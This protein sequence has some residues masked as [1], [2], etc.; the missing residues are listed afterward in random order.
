MTDKEWLE[1]CEWVN[2]LNSDKVCLETF[3]INERVITFIKVR[4]DDF[5]C[6]GI[7]IEKDGRITS[8]YNDTITKNRTPAQIKAIIENLL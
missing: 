3:N 6:K 5:G 7:D 2:L 1:L 4:T 8:S